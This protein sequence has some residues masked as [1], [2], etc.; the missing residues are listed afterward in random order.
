[1]HTFAI[2]T[3]TVSL[4]LASTTLAMGD[5]VL[6]LVPNTNNVNVGDTI[7]VSVVLTQDGLN[8][9]GAVAPDLSLPLTAGFELT[10]FGVELSIIGSAFTVTDSTLALGFND[11]TGGTFSGNRF[12]KGNTFG[13]GLT[14]PAT[15]GTFEVTAVAGGTST[16]LVTDPT[17]LND[18]AFSGINEGLDTGV[19]ASFTSPA[20]GV[21]AVPEPSSVLFFMLL[22]TTLAGLRWSRARE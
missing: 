20:G 12:V 21:T 16:F 4:T 18:F 13:A 14:S 9:N 1:M 5:V 17:G 6:S 7:S 11:F 3:L 22:G 2:T 8:S 15:L 10:G 19:F